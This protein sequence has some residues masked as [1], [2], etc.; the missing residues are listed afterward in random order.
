MFSCTCHMQD[1]DYKNDYRKSLKSVENCD[2]SSGEEVKVNQM[3]VGEEI[4]TAN[5]N[6]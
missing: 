5:Q 1:S 6:Q 3:V 4:R 2:G